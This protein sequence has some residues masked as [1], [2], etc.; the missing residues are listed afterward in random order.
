MTFASRLRLQEAPAL[1]G[2]RVDKIVVDGPAHAVHDEQQHGLAA[3]HRSQD[4]LEQT[5][6]R[7]ERGVWRGSRSARGGKEVAEPGVLTLADVARPRQQGGVRF[8]QLGR[9][10][11]AEQRQPG[12]V[13]KGAVAALGLNRITQ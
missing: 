8:S 3:G 7:N 5:L 6:D 11:P 10:L 9:L 4:I 13:P 12:K 1:F 2:D